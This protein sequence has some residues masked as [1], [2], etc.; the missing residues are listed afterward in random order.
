MKGLAEMT[1]ENDALVRHA[2]ARRR[3]AIRNLKARVARVLQNPP[4][5][6]PVSSFTRRDVYRAI[7]EWFA[8]ERSNGVMR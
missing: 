1:A 4:V 6:G 3:R 7:D 2:E 5:G 8:A